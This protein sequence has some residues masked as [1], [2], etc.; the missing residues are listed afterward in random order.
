MA[1]F[2]GLWRLDVCS[3]PES[4]WMTDDSGQES[5]A[6]S[7][8]CLIQIS[9]KNNNNKQKKNTVNLDNKCS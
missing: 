4:Q 2:T 9:A 5:L 3:L 7:Q 6:A 1:A 8:M